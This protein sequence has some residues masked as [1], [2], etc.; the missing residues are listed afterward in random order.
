MVTLA[1]DMFVC[2]HKIICFLLAGFLLKSVNVIQVWLTCDL[3]I[4]TSDTLLFMMCVHKLWH[5][6]W[7]ELMVFVFLHHIP[8]QLLVFFFRWST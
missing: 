5:L 4:H 1:F 3:H 7:C 2:L 8:V 6:L